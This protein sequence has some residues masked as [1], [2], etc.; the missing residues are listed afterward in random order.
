MGFGQHGG[1]L[2]RRRQ[3]QLLVKK[4][5]GL[6]VLPRTGGPSGQ[7]GVVE[8]LIGRI[9]GEKGGDVLVRFPMQLVLRR[10]VSQAPQR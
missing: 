7:S 10:S 8:A 4:D 9:E 1:V 3:R 2:V 5:E 6:Q